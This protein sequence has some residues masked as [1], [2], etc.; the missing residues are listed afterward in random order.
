MTIATRVAIRLILF[1]GD[2]EFEVFTTSGFF[3]SKKGHV[4]GSR[5][6]DVTRVGML[7]FG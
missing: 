6:C 7:L 5:G 3:G 4:E 2:V 1:T